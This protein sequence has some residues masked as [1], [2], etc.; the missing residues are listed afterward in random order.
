MAFEISEAGIA[1]ARIGAQAELDFQP[2][3]PG[4]LAVSPLKENVVDAEIRGR[5][6]GAGAAQAA[7]KRKDVA[8]ILPDFCTRM[9]VLDFDSFPS[10]AKEQTR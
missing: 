3:K 10:D 1:A 8:L 9:T 4:A 6:A 7:R 2:L 5:G